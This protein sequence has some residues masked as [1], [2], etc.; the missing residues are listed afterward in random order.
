[1]NHCDRGVG[2]FTYINLV[3]ASKFYA[4]NSGSERNRLFLGKKKMAG[5]KDD[6]PPTV[7]L[8]RGVICKN[9]SNIPDKETRT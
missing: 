9:M 8:G 4:A 1:M 3:E 7:D 6:V 2:L 5:K